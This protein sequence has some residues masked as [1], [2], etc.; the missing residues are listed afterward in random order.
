MH[1]DVTLVRTPANVTM[2]NDVF[3][4]SVLLTRIDFH[5][6]LGLKE[7]GRREGGGRYREGGD[8]EMGGGGSDRDE[9]GALK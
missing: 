5:S 9:D 7:G 4:T 6:G 8:T 3:F 1:T 2:L